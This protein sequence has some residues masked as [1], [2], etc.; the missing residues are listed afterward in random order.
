MLRHIITIAFRS[1]MRNK[2]SFLINLIGLSTGLGCVLFIYL[3]VSDE[4]EVD[5]FHEKNE[6][7]YQVIQNFE[8]AQGIM[9]S[10]STPGPLAKAL[11]AEIPEIEFATAISNWEEIPKGILSHNKISLASSGLVAS[12]NF[13]EVFSFDLIHGNKKQ[14][15][16]GRNQ[17]V[18]SEELAQKLFPTS[19]DVIG[20][21]LAWKNEWIDTTYQVSGVFAK[22]PE[23][24]TMQFDFVLGIE[25]EFEN[26]DYA[27]DWNGNYAETCLVLTKGSDLN[28]INAKITKLIRKKHTG[29]KTY[30]LF[31]QK[32]ADKYLYGQY[33]NGVASGGRIT[34]VKFFSL[35][36][37][38]ILLIACIN[39]MNLATARASNKIKEIGVKKTIGANRGL[40][41][42]QFL[43]E[44]MLMALFSLLLALLV[45]NALLPYFNAVTAK[46]LSLHIDTYSL[47]ALSSI[48]VFTGLVSGSYP[49]FYLSGFKTAHVLKGKLS[50]R[51]SV[52]W[53]RKGLVVFQFVLSLIF[54]V[55]VLVV[56]N[57]MDYIQTKN[58]GFQRDHVLTFQRPSNSDDIPVFLSEI[59]NI[60]GVQA[61]SNMS[62]SIL[63]EVYNQSGYSWRG[64]DS[65]K[66]FLFKSPIIGYDLIETLEMELLQGRSYS[67]QYKEEA[68][69]VIINESARKMMQLEDPIGKIIK[70]GKK[71]QREIIG[72]VHDFQYGSMYHKI[73]PA[74]FRFTST[75]RNILVK[76]QPGYEQAV[77]RKSEEIFKKFHPEYP[78]EYVFMDAEYQQL[79]EAESRVAKLSNVF[80]LLAI[81]ISCLGL[82]GLA[83][84]SAE[85]RSKEIG[86]RKVL[87]A[88]VWDIINMLS[89]DFTRMVIFSILIAVP[90]SYLLA[91]QWLN[92]FAYRIDMQWWFFA[93]A[94][95]ATLLIAW[96]T[97]GLQTYKAAS[98]RPVHALRDE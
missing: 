12:E 1:F 81:L 7:L 74:I 69:K 17:I 82:L 98:S 13:F 22:L 36:A 8:S 40:L 93:L 50:N 3:W 33:E 72:V 16:S 70:Y 46:Q 78:F 84:F 30:S 35:I 73:E 96:L 64:Q 25:E 67:R 24:S 10:T 71:N 45:V 32:Y 31:V 58:L 9:T 21:T 56:R 29:R 59:K 18:L 44:S 76:T 28:K 47:L 6:Q 77:I 90:V 37:V 92:N 60:P 43:S 62:H 14:V 94:G 65:D 83:Q 97:V 85:K 87:G 66:K 15:L 2:G 39:F 38:F 89:S 26:N 95:G 75:G 19:S 5:K 79:Y 61:A 48:L 11:A 63:S 88:S 53:I 42:V 34:Y 4:L 52:L 86:I 57:Q 68:S 27:R 54:I 55:G 49:A 20:K 23:N 91:E 41:I 51:I 80:T